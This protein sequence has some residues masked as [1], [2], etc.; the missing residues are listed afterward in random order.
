MEGVLVKSRSVIFM[1]IA[2]LTAAGALSCASQSAATAAPAEPKAAAPT[3]D[4]QAAAAQPSPEP[5]VGP[6]QV[7]WKDMTKPQRGKYMFMV[8]MP[9]MK[10]LF[11]TFDGKEF[12]EFGCGTCHGAGAKDRS[13]TMPNPE[14]FALPS[15]P[16]EFGELMKQKPEWVKFMGEKVKPEMAKLLGLKEFEPQN[17][18]PGTFGCSNCHTSKGP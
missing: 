2:G 9:K 17:P 6:P 13:F 7:A 11:R 1:A 8:V 4:H 3:P 16:A 14:I 5:I 18:Q 10:E 12:A 15:T